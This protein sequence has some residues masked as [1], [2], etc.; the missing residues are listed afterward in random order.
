MFCVYNKVVPENVDFRIGG[1]RVQEE[2][3]TTNFYVLR[4]CL[5]NEIVNVGT[6]N[7]FPNLPNTA[8]NDVA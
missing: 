8:E 7:A 6:E 2:I 4:A 1:C 3:I 5:R